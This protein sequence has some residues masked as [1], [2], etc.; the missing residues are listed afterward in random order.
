MNVIADAVKAAVPGS[1][2]FLVLALAVGVLLLYRPGGARRWGRRWLTALVTAYWLL[3]VPVGAELLAALLSY[4]YDRVVSVPVGTRAI[5]VLDSG[6]NRVRADGELIETVSTLSALRSIEAN[7]VWRL[8]PDSWV[9]IQGGRW[10]EDTAFAAEGETLKTRLIEAGVLKDRI[11]LDSQSR[12]TFEHARTLKPLLD[13]LHIEQFVL[14]TSPTHIRRAT[15]TFRAQG[16]RPLPSAAPLRADDPDW[17]WTNVRPRASVLRLS[18]EALR[19]YLGLVYYW[20]RGW[21]S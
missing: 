18:E 12:N 5:V 2:T 1:V 4:G 17:H 3:S 15:L 9:I 11:V 14:V 16:L 20:S 10:Q 13:R 19:E 21:L 7:R 6:T 8:L